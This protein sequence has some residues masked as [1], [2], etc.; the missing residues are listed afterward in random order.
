M[1]RYPVIDFHSHI[2]PKMDDGSKG[3][4]MSLEMLQRMK[5]YGCD[6]VVSTSHYYRMNED[7]PDFLAR[8]TASYRH[9]CA[10]IREEPEWNVPSIALGSEVAFFFGIESEE[11][12]GKLCIGDTDILLLEM[13]FAPW[14]IYEFNAVSALCYD[15]R[16]RVILA[17]YERFAEFQ[18]GN[19]IYD[20]ILKL[21]VIVQINAE[22]LQSKFGWNS[23]RWIRMFE[24]GRAKLLG[25]DAHNLTSRAPNLDVARETLRTKLSADV[26]DR[27]DEFGFRLL[28]DGAHK[29]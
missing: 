6:L 23:K 15:R 7:I 16:F 19:E 8:R 24:E 26:L 1:T 9:L 18:K 14:S 21:P 10:R 17:H 5:N 13:P 3:T 27:I 20:R 2:L 12:L 22:S 28:A 29:R 4:D 25:T 11:N